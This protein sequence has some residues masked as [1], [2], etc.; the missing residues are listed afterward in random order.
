MY[1]KEACSSHIYPRGLGISIAVFLWQDFFG[2]EHVIFGVSP[3]ICVCVQAIN[4]L[5]VFLQLH[6]WR[7]R[8][9]DPCPTGRLVPLKKVTKLHFSLSC[10]FAQHKKRDNELG[11]NIAHKVV[12]GPACLFS[13]NVFLWYQNFFSLFLVYDFFLTLPQPRYRTKSAAVVCHKMQK[14]SQFR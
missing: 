8:E 12:Q 6:F 4:W 7:R 10:F 14:S 2:N 3:H 5:L 13:Q 11:Y 1:A 9:Q